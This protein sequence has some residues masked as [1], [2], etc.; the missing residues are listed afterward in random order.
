MSP[1]IDRYFKA[2]YSALR[3]VGKNTS[4]NS[5]RRYGISSLAFGVPEGAT[6]HPFDALDAC[7]GQAFHLLPLLSPLREALNAL[8]SL[9]EIPFL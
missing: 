7:S 5:Q 8:A 2:S 3:K 6:F 9:R 1:P 4:R